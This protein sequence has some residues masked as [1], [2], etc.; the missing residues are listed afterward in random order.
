MVLKPSLVILS[1]FMFSLCI[2]WEYLRLTQR[3]NCLSRFMFNWTILEYLWLECLVG[4]ILFNYYFIYCWCLKCCVLLEYIWFTL[5]ML[6]TWSLNG[7]WII[8]EYTWL[9]CTIS[10]CIKYFIPCSRFNIKIIC[11]YLRSNTCCSLIIHIF[12]IYI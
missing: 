8:T 1:L 6:G 4:T 5:L 7:D 12:K 3:I 9:E 11:L 2:V 10:I